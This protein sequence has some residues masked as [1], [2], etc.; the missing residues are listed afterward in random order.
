MD[1]GRTIEIDPVAVVESLGIQLLFHE[2]LTAAYELRVW[3]RELRKVVVGLLGIGTTRSRM[4]LQEYVRV[5]GYRGVAV[6]LD[7][8]VGR[9]DGVLC[10]TTVQDGW[11]LWERQ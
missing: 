5:T 8:V 7:V 9:H 4:V 10:S 1:K 11:D 6:F 3:E 2:R